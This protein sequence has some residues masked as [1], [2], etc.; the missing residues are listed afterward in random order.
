MLRFTT[1]ATCSVQC[2][3]PPQSSP[4]TPHYRFCFR[5]AGS[6]SQVLCISHH[7][8]FHREATTTIQIDTIDKTTRVVKYQRHS[9]NL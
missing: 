4:T 5:P 9:K 7:P 6:E 8:A 1:P 2:T 3:T